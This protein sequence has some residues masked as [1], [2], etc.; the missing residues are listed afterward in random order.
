MDQNEV[1]FSL[2]QL[3]Y[4]Q[5]IQRRNTWLARAMLLGVLMSMLFVQMWMTQRNYDAMIINV[6]QTRIAQVNLFEAQVE[7]IRK[8][9]ARV[10]TLQ[11]SVARQ[12]AHQQRA[13]VSTAN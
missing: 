3:E 2:D 4:F 7:R 10:I 8:L 12:E 1:N 6:D 11:Q 5:Q 9:E 13:M